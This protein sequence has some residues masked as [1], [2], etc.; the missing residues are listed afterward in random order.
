MLTIQN[1]K[2]MNYRE[3]QTQ[4][5]VMGFKAN[6]SA[7][8]LRSLI[9]ARF[10]QY[11][12]MGAAI[13]GCDNA[14]FECH[15][16]GSVV[17]VIEFNG[18]QTCDICIEEIKVLG[19]PIST[20]ADD[21]FEQFMNGDNFTTNTEEKRAEEIMAKYQIHGTVAHGTCSWCGA[22]NLVG[23]KEHAGEFA[24]NS[25]VETQM[26]E[27]NN[28][29]TV[30]N[31]DN[32]IN[33]NKENDVEMKKPAFDLSVRSEFV[34]VPYTFAWD[35]QPEPEEELIQ[36]VAPLPGQTTFA[37]ALDKL[38]TVANGASEA[39]APVQ[40][41]TTNQNAKEN[42]NM[43]QPSASKLFE[44]IE[45]TN[46]T[47][48]FRQKDKLVR[49]GWSVSTA[50]PYIQVDGQPARVQMI[51]TSIDAFKKFVNG[52]HGDVAR[53]VK[54]LVRIRKMPAAVNAQLHQRK[55]AANEVS[56]ELVISSQRQ[57]QNVSVV[58]RKENQSKARYSGTIN[59]SWLAQFRTEFESNE[60]RKP[61]GLEI[62][63]AWLSREA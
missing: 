14:L 51:Q 46:L 18:K 60:G 57:Q 16:C 25:C 12:E 48:A 36:Y 56:S 47:V 41:A 10:E 35:E 11:E 33:N 38:I 20:K 43:E 5:K 13:G 42:V 22:T 7:D 24:C 44:F 9:V 6:Q 28:S 62:R 58:D 29:D 61:T 26:N 30:V 19:S 54:A 40:S 63:D 15:A 39:S 49:I 1:V 59:A 31:S 32:D 2:E 3:L 8:V 50:R 27:E 21:E 17:N 37:K 23:I 55:R 53:I 52:K 4:A 34:Y 45:S